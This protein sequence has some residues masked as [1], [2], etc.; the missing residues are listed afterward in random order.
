MVVTFVLGNFALVMSEGMAFAMEKAIERAREI[1]VAF[2]AI[3]GSNHA[4]TMDFY[5]RMALADGMIGICGTNAL[6]T[7]APWGGRDKIVGINPIGIA[8]PASDPLLLNLLENY[9]NALETT[10][11]LDELRSKWLED[12]SWV[13]RLP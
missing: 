5:A 1:N 10:G 9:L 8:L 6:P 12:G 4:G 7:M 13:G 2:A 3:G 11:A